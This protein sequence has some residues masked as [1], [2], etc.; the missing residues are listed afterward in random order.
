[1][2]FNDLGSLGIRSLRAFSLDPLRKW[3]LH[4]KDTT[5]TIRKKVFRCIYREHVGLGVSISSC[6]KSMLE[7]E[8]IRSI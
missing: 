3:W 5:Y 6:N 4:F 8:S 7:H 1:M 2:K